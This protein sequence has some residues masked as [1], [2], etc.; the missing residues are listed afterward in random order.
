MFGFHGDL[1]GN[2]ISTRSSIHL[3]LSPHQLHAGEGS[4]AS[5]DDACAGTQRV[6]LG[7]R[8]RDKNWEISLLSVSLS[9]SKDIFYL[10]GRQSCRKGETGRR[11]K[12]ER[13]HLLVRAPNGSDDTCWVC[14]QSGARSSFL[15]SYMADETVSSKILFDVSVK[16]K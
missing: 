12:R 7:S 4:S 15:V 2:D 16:S 9:F 14:L 8:V 10:F 6:E 11:R 1:W 13:N 5:W 3:F